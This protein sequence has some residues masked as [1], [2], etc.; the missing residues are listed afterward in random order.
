[1][2]QTRNSTRSS[3]ILASLAW[4]CKIITDCILENNIRDSKIPQPK[5]YDKI[6]IKVSKRKK[7]LGFVVMK[8]LTFLCLVRFEQSANGLPQIVQEY[9][10]SPVTTDTTF[11]KCQVFDDQQIQWLV[12][13][14]ELFISK[15]TGFFIV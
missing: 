6:E 12:F 11:I 8:H 7:S 13:I 2:F 15:E 4:T 3:S 14:N 10:F 1:M 9:G 5:R